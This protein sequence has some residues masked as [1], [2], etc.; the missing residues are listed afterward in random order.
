MGMNITLHEQ[1]H[2]ARDHH[3]VKLQDLSS[4]VQLPQKNH[5]RSTK[6]ISAVASAPDDL[7]QKLS[8]TKKQQNNWICSLASIDLVN[9]GNQ[10]FPGGWIITELLQIPLMMGSSSRSQVCKSA[11]KESETGP[12][13]GHHTPSQPLHNLSQVVWTCYILV[14]EASGDL[15][16]LIKSISAQI[17]QHTVRPDVDNKP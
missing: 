8:D 5:M 11:E 9:K 15:I 16:G 14:Q 4:I 7:K 3:Q 12:R 2:P 13:V 10:S 17:Q 1:W 6:C